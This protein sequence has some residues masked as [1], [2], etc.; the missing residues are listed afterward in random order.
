MRVKTTS[1]IRGFAFLS[2]V[3]VMVAFS[4]IGV[5][6]V[7]MITG[8]GSM[9]EDEY[10]S[11]QAFDLANAGIAY[12]AEQLE[13]DSDWSDN[14]GYTKTMAPGQFTISYITQ[15]TNQCTVK[16]V[17]TVEGVS[18]AVQQK[19]SRGSGPKAFEKAI[20]TEADIDVSGAAT[21]TV[22]G[23]VSAGGTVT[24][25][26]GV[27][28]EGNVEE[29]NSTA[30]IPQPDWAYWQAV[31]DHV[32]TRNFNFSPGTYSGIYYITGNTTFN[33]NVTLN[34][35][36]VCEGK[37]TMN[38][39]SNITINATPPNPAI[40]SG[41]TLR[42]NGNSGVTINGYMISTTIATITGNNDMTVT[43]GVVAEGDIT[44]S[45]SSI[46]DIV[47]DPDYA[48]SGDGFIGG[49]G[50]GGGETFDGWEETI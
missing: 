4:T 49:E 45:G 19:F 31:A 7:A 40:I 13:N 43:G 8:S 15:S 10:H 39:R 22:D 12:E 48:P 30:E 17:G 16:S 47:Y 27:T 24:T 28:F 18:R 32:I 37:V 6:A 5:G 34:G 33:S 21:G 38:S 9:M 14:T 20:Y 3:F 26:E 50:G 42:L 29:N 46:S 35:T 44:M 11:Q 25:D 2:V 36:V 41:N 23:D 1:G